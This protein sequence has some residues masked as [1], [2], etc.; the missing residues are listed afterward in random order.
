ML[1]M[2]SFGAFER[3]A[4]EDQGIR[5][6]V[7]A[8]RDATARRESWM[9]GLI[10]SR[11]R[12]VL[13]TIGVLLALDVGRSLWARVGYARPVEAWQPEAHVY[14]DLAWPP[15]VD[16]PADAPL[17]RRTYAQRCAVC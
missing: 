17:G 8:E 15:G 1:T 5:L 6:P 3:H 16:L 14:A 9:R 12:V 13:M 10:G 11:R 7:D 4:M 2:S